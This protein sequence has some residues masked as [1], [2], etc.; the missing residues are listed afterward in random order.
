MG[1]IP[2]KWSVI[3]SVGLPLLVCLFNS[4]SFGQL[5]WSSGGFLP[6]AGEA[7]FS[8]A[9][10]NGRYVATGQFG[11]IV[12]SLDSIDWFDR[13]ADIPEMLLWTVSFG[14][15]IFLTAGSDKILTSSDGVSWTSQ[16]VETGDYLLATAFGNGAYVA[17][18]TRGTIV[19]STNG[20]EWIDRSPENETA[21]FYSICHGNNIFV[22]V[23]IDATNGYKS[24]FYYSTD[25]YSWSETEPFPSTLWQVS[26]GNGFFVAVG[27]SGTVMT[28]TDG[29]QW[30]LQS[31]GT[32]S[33]LMS[34]AFGSRRFVAAGEGGSILSSPDGHAWFDCSPGVD[35]EFQSVTFGS[36]RF[37]AIGES[38]A[39][40]FAS[41]TPAF[42]GRQA[43]NVSTDANTV[44]FNFGGTTVL[45]PPGNGF[46]EAIIDMEL[47]SIAGKRVFAAH[48]P[49]SEGEMNVSIPTGM[50]VLT[51]A[52][53]GKR[54]SMPVTVTR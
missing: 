46:T 12:A 42:V 3:A 38:G 8:I 54:I 41:V 11:T 28:S 22:A 23:N 47:F 37:V 29:V 43:G 4:N 45:F 19:T 17:V 52:C 40:Y 5:K 53:G 30:S 25:G 13:A 10:G 9:Y 16:T 1:I 44:K 50:Y 2:D 18:G 39:V 26:F 24:S 15:G 49:R 33:R 21:D 27:D 7:Y 34:V 14:N 48:C 36:D 20:K 51:L 31:T 32:S 35:V 6:E